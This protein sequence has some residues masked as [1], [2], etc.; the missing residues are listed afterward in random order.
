MIKYTNNKLSELYKRINLFNKL[1]KIRHYQFIL[2]KIRPFT[3]AR[4]NWKK[5]EYDAVHSK[6]I[7]KEILI[8]TSSGG[9]WPCSSFESLLAISL[10][11]RGASVKVLLNDGIVEACQ[12]CESYWLDESKFIKEGNKSF[13]SSSYKY[14]KEM[15]DTLGIEV[16]NYR[17]FTETKSIK[18]IPKIN[19][20]EHAYAG[21]LRYLGRG[22]IKNNSLHKAVLDKFIKSSELTRIIITNVLE[23]YNF[24]TALF[25]HGIYVP[26]GVIGDVCRYK[27]INIVNWGPSYRKGTVL[28]SHNHSYHHTMQLDDNENWSSINWTDDKE[29]KLNNYLQSR[30]FGSNDWISFQKVSETSNK[31]IYKKLNLNSKLPI[32]TLLTNVIWDAQLHFKNSAFKSMLDWLFHTIE[33]FEKNTLA[34]LVIRIHPAEDLGSVPSNQSVYNEIID[35]YGSIPKH[36]RVVRPLDSLST[37]SLVEMSDS[38]IVFGTK[39]AIEI[40]CQGKIVIVAGDAWARNKGFTIDVSS[41]DEYNN[42]L[43]LLPCRK[44]LDSKTIERAKKYAYYLF[45][46]RMIN[47]SSIEYS[48]YFSPYKLNISKTSQLLPG[49]DQGL[50]IICNG[51]LHKTEFI[52][53]EN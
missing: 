29:I 33:Y 32:V 25:H 30:R 1:K 26:Q 2:K 4:F 21:A 5:I 8:A 50:D 11:L 9:I 52:K 48:K 36:I 41:I 23:K 20:T 7:N 37:Y 53:Y 45:F 14:A 17:D 39:M 31:D 3:T 46:Y 40:A 28:F 10:K 42:E 51:I 38:C 6:K 35:R 15:F 27:N 34:Q 49:K 12:E 18:D 16:L 19:I 24:D 43:S 22:N 47:L 44:N 13:C